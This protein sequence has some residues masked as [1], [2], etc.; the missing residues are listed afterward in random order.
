MLDSDWLI[1]LKT[2]WLYWMIFISASL[3]SI[4][5]LILF[6]V[7]NNWLISLLFLFTFILFLRLFNSSDLKIWYISNLPFNLF[8]LIEMPSLNRNERV[9]C[10][11]CGRE[12]THKDASSHR[13][14]CGVLKC[15]NCNFY[16]YSSEELFYHFKKR[17][18]QHNFKLCA[19][20]SPKTLQEK[21]NLIIL[22]EN[23]N[24]YE[25]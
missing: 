3:N 25:N 18:Y 15:L 11:E 6:H 16:T 23:R 9:A 8:F 20:H 22:V 7:K 24:Y 19:Q 4:F 2:P 10:L 21:V 14:T 17:H 12:Y 13:R 1:L 5:I